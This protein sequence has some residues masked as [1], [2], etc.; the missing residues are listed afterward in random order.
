MQVQARQ[1]HAL[2]IPLRH[3]F[4]LTY[5]QINQCTRAGQESSLTYFFGRPQNTRLRN[6]I[7]SPFLGNFQALEK[8]LL[9]CRQKLQ[10]SP[11][12][13]GAR[14]E[15]FPGQSAFQ[16]FLARLPNHVVEVQQCANLEKISRCMKGCK[17][18][19]FHT[20][21]QRSLLVESKPK[22]KL[23]TVVF[24]LS[25]TVITV[26]EDTKALLTLRVYRQ[27]VYLCIYTTC[28][29]LEENCDQSY[30]LR[31]IQKAQQF[32]KNLRPKAFS[33]ETYSYSKFS[34]DEF[35]QY[36]IQKVEL[37]FK[38]NPFS[39]GRQYCIYSE[40]LCV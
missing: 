5:Y 32:T 18:P 34:V 37:N 19:V 38:S 23:V 26:G 22:S 39:I 31:K 11:N 35:S 24:S 1:N 8:D 33:R 9:A 2:F 36:R 21:N 3:G 10:V 15:T 28:R 17:P 14:E 7:D 25:F 27:S 20:K 6:L 4:L 13:L 30:A 12:V 40:T 29:V 16:E